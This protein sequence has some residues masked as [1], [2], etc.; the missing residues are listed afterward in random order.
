[1]T[2]HH[3]WKRVE[4]TR[5]DLSSILDVEGTIF[6]FFRHVASGKKIRARSVSSWSTIDT[7]ARCCAS[8]RRW[9]MSIIMPRHRRRCEGISVTSSILERHISSPRG[10][11]PVSGSVAAVHHFGYNKQTRA[12]Y[13]SS[14]YLGLRLAGDAGYECRSLSGWICDNNGRKQWRVRI[15]G[16]FAIARGNFCYFVRNGIF[17]THVLGSID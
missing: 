9:I 8:K 1:M 16:Q 6:P 10:S 3:M 14:A 2:I 5:R 15:N 17:E 4:A 11:G 12:W 13:P 7:F